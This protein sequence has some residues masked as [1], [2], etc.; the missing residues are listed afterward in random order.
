MTEPTVCQPNTG[1]TVQLPLLF[2]PPVDSPAGI[3]ASERHPVDTRRT[4]PTY[5]S[6]PTSPRP[7][8]RIPYREINN[9][10]PLP[11]AAFIFLSAPDERNLQKYTTAAA[12]RGGTMRD[13]RMHGR[14]QL[15]KS[16]SAPR[17]IRFSET[18]RVAIKDTEMFLQCIYNSHNAQR[19]KVLGDLLM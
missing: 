1:S 3:Y 4:P 19:Q 7:Y 6:P 8:R 13:L 18:L 2:I 16:F 12:R 9:P 11:P 14:A 10:T 15:M 5:L 17:S